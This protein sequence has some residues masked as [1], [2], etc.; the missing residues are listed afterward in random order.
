MSEISKTMFREYPILERNEMLRANADKI[1]EK[2]YQ[3]AFDKEEILEMKINLSDYSVE[4]ANLQ[5]ELERI[6]S[7]I[8]EKIKA[9]Q[10][11]IEGLVDYVRLGSRQVTEDCYKFVDFKEESVAY[12]NTEGD[13][14]FARNLNS[15]DA[16]KT[17]HSAMRVNKAIGYE[18]E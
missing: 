9:A 12:Y 7:P 18:Q 13:L 2:T 14:I 1:E 10:K 8:K 15:E 3:K 17:I 11:R 5:A 4:I 6:S 16:Q